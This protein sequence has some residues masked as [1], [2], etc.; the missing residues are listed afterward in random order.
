M[1]YSDPFRGTIYNPLPIIL[2]DNSNGGE[3]N[4]LSKM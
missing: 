2:G 1:K 4:A 3:C